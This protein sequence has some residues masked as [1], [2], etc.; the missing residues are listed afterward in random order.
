[1]D[2][3][4]LSTNG[5]SLDVRLRSTTQYITIIGLYLVA[6]LPLTQLEENQVLAFYR[7]LTGH[8]GGVPGFN[9]R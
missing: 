9:K 6:R 7:L 8:G 1:M 3:C 5:L 4:V 2:M